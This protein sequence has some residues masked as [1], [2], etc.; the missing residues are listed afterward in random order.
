MLL[1]NTNRRTPARS[2][3]PINWRVASTLL[4][5]YSEGRALPVTA[6]RCRTQPAP[7]SAVS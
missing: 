6:A 3:A 2:H 7:A 1:M 4:R 5:T